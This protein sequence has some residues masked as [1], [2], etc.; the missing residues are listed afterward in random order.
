[1]TFQMK[2]NEERE[3]AHEEGRL[4]GRAEMIIT[5]LQTGKTPEDIHAFCSISLDEILKV[6]EKLDSE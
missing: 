5:M 6:K 2:L 1:M 4:E 3:E